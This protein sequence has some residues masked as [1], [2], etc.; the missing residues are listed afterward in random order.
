MEQVGIPREK[1]HDLPR[2]RRLSGQEQKQPTIITGLWLETEPQR[3]NANRQTWRGW[4]H[5]FRVPRLTMHCVSS[6]AEELRTPAFQ[7]PGVWTVVTAA[8]SPISQIKE[9]SG[10]FTRRPWDAQEA[11]RLSTLIEQAGI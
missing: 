6:L 7:V 9:G 5:D 2:G 1:R 8:D 11:L 3:E 10:D 4:A